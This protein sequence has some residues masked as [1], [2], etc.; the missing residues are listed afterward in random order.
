M[1]AL[2]D[3]EALYTYEGTHDICSMI[4]GKEITGL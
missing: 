4:A 3:L 1:K 2:I